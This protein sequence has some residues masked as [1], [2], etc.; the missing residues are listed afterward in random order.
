M[1]KIG[2][3]VKFENE[4]GDIFSGEITEVLS[5]SYDDVRLRDGEVEYWS[6]KTKIILVSLE[7]PTRPQRSR[8]FTVCM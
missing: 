4:V 1:L 8:Q 6:K 7:S 3:E 2:N 5:D